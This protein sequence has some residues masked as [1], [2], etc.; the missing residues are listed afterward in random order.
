MFKD[1]LKELRLKYGLTQQEL[2]DKIYVSRSAICKWEMGNGIPSNPNLEALCLLFNVEED[3]LFSQQDQTEGKEITK[4]NHHVNIA[5]V[6]LIIMSFIFLMIILTILSTTN[7]II[8]I[9]HPINLWRVFNT[10]ELIIIIGGLA[11][12]FGIGLLLIFNNNGFLTLNVNDQKRKKILSFGYALSVIIFFIFIVLTTLRLSKPNDYQGNVS[13][14][15][16]IQD[17]IITIVIGLIPLVYT[18]S[19]QKLKIVKLIFS[20]INYL[21]FGVGVCFFV[22]TMYNSFH[23]NQ[24]AVALGLILNSIC[25]LTSII[26]STITLIVELKTK[27]R[28]KLS[29]ILNTITIILS[30]LMFIIIITIL[31]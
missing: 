15:M 27:E 13:E 2:A 31:L 14:T 18:L 9:K 1:K 29:I 12:S 10:Y 28:N 23:N 24:T 8:N 16:F 4:R 17:L 26:I 30:I 3:W 11:L 21:I 22:Y 20:I 7:S 25:G 5:N 19:S 6:I